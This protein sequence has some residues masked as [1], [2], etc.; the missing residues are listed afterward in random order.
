M[1]EMNQFYAAKPRSIYFII[2]I[3][4][5][6]DKTEIRQINNLSKVIHLANPRT[7]CLCVIFQTLMTSPYHSSY[8]QKLQN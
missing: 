6:D 7:E 1:T 8:E 4:Q 2:Q 5:P 3:S